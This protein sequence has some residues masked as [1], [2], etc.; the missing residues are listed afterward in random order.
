MN[1]EGMRATDAA[2]MRIC[3]NHFT[4][5][6]SILFFASAITVTAAFAG[7]LDNAWLKGTTDKN[8]LSYAPDE[9]MVFTI[10]PMELDGAVPDGKYNLWWKISDDFGRAEE[11]T[12]PFTGEPMVFTASLGQP[13]FVRLEAY[14]CTPDGKRYSKKFLGDTS[15]PE[16][17][18]AMNEF[19]KKPHHVFFDGGAAVN[20]DALE[21]PEEPADFDE[22][23]ARQFERL[24]KVPIK[25]DR[26]ET[27]CPNPQVRRWA[28]S[29]TCAGLRPVTGYL[30]IPKAVEEGKTFPVRL[31][32]HGYNG[33]SFLPNKPG[34]AS[35]GE[36]VL[37][38]NAHGLKLPE[39]GATEAD[40]K[41]LRWEVRS[42]GKSYAFDPEQN[43]DPEVA[44]FNGMVL[45][46]K[47]ALQFLKT[48][49]GW[50][51]VDIYASGGSQGGLQ[52][53]WAAGCGE[54]VTK[55]Y[56]GITWCCDL[57]MDNN[58]KGWYIPYV[59]GLAYYDAVTW[60]KRIPETCRTE[61]TRAGIG[62]YTCPPMGLAKLWNAIP[63]SNKIIKWVQGS[64]HGYVP[65]AYE[66]RDFEIRK[67]AQ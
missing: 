30:S 44:Y 63:G 37:N 13:G 65:P 56:S 54:G 7:V 19:E 11:G 14:V 24:D 49:K 50:N 34:W 21:P 51:G 10:T 16:G 33:D 5:K 12:R 41:A 9:P 59:D 57:P 28:V 35:A 53:I 60:G 36:I 25:C 26:V 29:I 40:R 22:F 64:Q 4:M 67:I 48:L 17:Q 45:R 27:D 46:V 18:K 61:I 8:P 42:N 32:T 31:E 43:K 1:N 38:I 23:W 39:F 3:Y 66:G 15:T 20:P 55:A 52:T 47:R 6:K 62:D 58:R 2:A